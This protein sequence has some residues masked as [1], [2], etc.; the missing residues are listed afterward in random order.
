MTV[1]IITACFNS[2]AVIRT[3]MESVLRQTWP[4]IEYLIV[5]G[6]SDDGTLE[7]IREYEPKFKG[8]M[9]WISEPDQGC[10]TRST[11]AS[12]WRGAR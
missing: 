9:R 12:A 4:D 1:T 11:R 2:A 3:A 6:G 8:R 5:D 10:T 7:L